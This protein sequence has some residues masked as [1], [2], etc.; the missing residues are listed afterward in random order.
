MSIE[1]YYVSEN[2]LVKAEAVYKVVRWVNEDPDRAI[3]VGST[4]VGM[5]IAVLGIAWLVKAFNEK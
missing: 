2:N 5:G 1:Q 4:L 3:D